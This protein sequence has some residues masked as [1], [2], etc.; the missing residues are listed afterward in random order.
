MKLAHVQAK[1]MKL[2]HVKAK[3]LLFH[4]N[5]VTSVHNKFV[6]Q[7]AAI[8]SCAATINLQFFVIQFLIIISMTA[9]I[10]PLTNRIIE[11]ETQYAPSMDLCNN[12][13][14]NCSTRINLTFLRAPLAS[15]QQ[16]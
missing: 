16:P 15:S 3:L 6:C 5:K 14:R 12:S 13:S 2:A 1:P 8:C 4:I 9:P 10:A 7:N 11:T